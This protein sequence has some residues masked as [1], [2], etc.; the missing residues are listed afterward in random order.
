MTIMQF[1][2]RLSFENPPAP[3]R[4]PH[5]AMPM[6]LP[7]VFEPA[8]RA[9][10]EYRVVVIDPREEEPLDESRAAE[11]GADGWLLAAVL[12]NP[13]GRY[14]GRIYYYFVRAAD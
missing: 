1:W 4:P 2:P 10:W 3:Q 7:M 9:R 12:E 13:A 6:P 5:P 14:G 11:L 8:A